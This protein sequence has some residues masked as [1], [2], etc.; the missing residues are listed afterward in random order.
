ML[1][2]SLLLLA[3]L[4]LVSVQPRMASAHASLIG[5]DP[6]EGA[7]LDAAP[8]RVTLSF[9]EP[10][11]LI[12][13]G[14]HLFDANGPVGMLEA[15]VTG[16]DVLLRLPGD[17]GNGSYVVS[18]RVISADG[19]PISGVLLF[20]VGE[21]GGAPIVVPESAD[22]TPV[23]SVVQGIAYAGL[24]AAVGLLLFRLV[25]T[26][27]A[28]VD[29]MPALVAA[30]IAVIGHV[31]LIPLTTLRADGRPLGDI[32]TSGAWNGGTDSTTV[33][34]ALIVGVACIGAFA[35][36]AA[37]STT[38]QFGGVIAG[39]IAALVTL[40]MVGHT[41]TGDFSVILSGIDIAHGLAAAI[42]FGGLIGLAR[43][44]RREGSTDPAMSARVVSRFS[45]L[46]GVVFAL[47]A[48]SGAYLSFQ[49]LDSLDDLVNTTYG[50]LLIAKIA[51]LLIPFALAAWN[52][53]AL[54]PAVEREPEASSAWRRLRGVVIVE[55]ALLLVVVGLTGFLV[56]QSPQGEPAA[57]ESGVAATPFEG[58]TSV[59][60][61]T[62]AIS[63]TPGGQGDNEMRVEVQD[64]AGE[65]VELYGDI[66]VELTLPAEELGPITSTLAAA[67]TPGAY[68]GTINVPIAGEWEVSII[69]RANRFEQ[70]VSTVTVPFAGTGD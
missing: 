45:T 52:R 39:C 50:R 23:V 13:A 38:R 33:I 60:D 12:D 22:I 70:S 31:L 29:R 21:A 53:L 16:S 18:W 5:T 2:P 25:I 37:R 69:L 27:D 1:T 19:H 68:A 48:A 15:E 66:V 64:S 8:E 44:L 59:D 41:R 54:V 35:G 17:M 47:A 6:A 7:V 57:A 61:M 3:I 28:R 67:D 14:Y 62:L 11:D 40:P 9:T 24:L 26:G 63:I 4:A 32:F 65:A 46:A 49:Y 58:T 43:F 20:S 56:L 30:I 55:V 34:V 51:V 42:W 10:V 36:T